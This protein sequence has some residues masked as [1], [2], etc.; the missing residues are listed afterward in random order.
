MDIMVNLL[1]GQKTADVS[2]LWKEPNYHGDI[3]LVEPKTATAKFRFPSGDTKITWTT[4]NAAGSDTCSI[5]VMVSGKELLE[6]IS[7]SW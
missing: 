5:L 6:Q 7:L 4:K 1:P 3:L 2:S